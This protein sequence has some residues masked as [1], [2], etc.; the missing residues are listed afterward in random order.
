MKVNKEDLR[1]VLRKVDDAEDWNFQF[2]VGQQISEE[3]ILP[4][5][6]VESL[7]T[8]PVPVNIKVLK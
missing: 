4:M 5:F 1:D 8:I 3:N 7:G 2:A 6:S